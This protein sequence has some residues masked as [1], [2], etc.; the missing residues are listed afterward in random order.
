MKRFVG[1]AIEIAA[2]FFHWQ[3]TQVSDSLRIPLFHII[4]QIFHNATIQNFSTLFK[5]P[6]MG[7]KKDTVMKVTDTYCF[8]I[9]TRFA[10]ADQFWQSSL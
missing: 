7:W 5:M 1:K 9:K 2:V 10:D 3:E 6:A 8:E 4:F